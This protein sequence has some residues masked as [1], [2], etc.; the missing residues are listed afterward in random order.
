MS[1]PARTASTRSPLIGSPAPV[2]PPG[3][4]STTDARSDLVVAA[5]RR[6]LPAPA[7][8]RR[9]PLPLLQAL[10][11]VSVYRRSMTRAHLAGLV[12]AAPRPPGLTVAGAQMWT[13]SGISVGSG[14]RLG[15]TAAGTI[16]VAG[17]DPGKSPAGDPSCLAA[18]SPPDT[19]VRLGGREAA[20]RAECSRMASAP[21][22][23]PGR[24]RLV[25]SWLPLSSACR[26]P[27]GRGRC[28]ALGRQVWREKAG[29]PSVGVELVTRACHARP[30]PPHSQRT[31]SGSPRLA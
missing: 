18:P 1:P 4:I 26:L 30:D 25:L 24:R 23:W 11:S 17:S 3:S 22:R 8:S 27:R 14:E 7:Q 28:R 16:Y 10:I 31:P 15:L 21:A 5:T 13:D 29:S 2:A 20:A 19:W 9:H 12:M 6:S